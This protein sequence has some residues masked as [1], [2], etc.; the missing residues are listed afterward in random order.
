M[1]PLR[2]DE[3]LDA[4]DARWSAGRVRPADVEVAGVSTDSREVAPEPSAPAG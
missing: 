4:V 1:I 2:L 3:I